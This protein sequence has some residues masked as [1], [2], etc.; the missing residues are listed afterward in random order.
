MAKD[1]ASQ[2]VSRRGL[3]AGGAAAVAGAGL[4]GP[5]RGIADA[6]PG[7][8]HRP[9]ANG[10]APVPPPIVLT[11]GTLL[12]PLTGRVTE[13][14]VIVLANRRV[15]AVA[16]ASKFRAK[17]MNGAQVIDLDD[18]WVVPGLLD[19]HT[20]ATSR[21]S[22][23]RA[24]HAGATTLRIASS[25][26]Y[27]D[28]G[29]QALAEWLPA[30]VPTIQPVGLF[31]RPLLGDDVLSDPRLAP[32]AAS[33]NAP[34]T[35]EELRLLVSVNLSRGAD[36]IKTWATGRAGVCEQDPQQT[37]YD[38]TQLRAIVEAARGRPV[39]CHSHGA[40]GCQNAVQAGVTSLE[41]GTFVTD[42]TLA[43]MRRRGTYFTPTISAVVDL[44]EPGGE[45]DEPCLQERGRTMLPVLEAAVRRAAAL[46]IPIAAGADTSY[47]EASVT[48]VATEVQYLHDAGLPALDALRAATTV[49]ARLMRLQ[50]DA[51]RIARGY[52]AD[53]LVVGASPLDDPATLQ[54][55][56][57]VI[58]GGAV[59]RN[60]L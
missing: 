40:V 2:G 54:S 57:L 29:L 50:G 32:L 42:E 16:D 51:G 48:S 27:A 49:A 8:H 36:H 18:A 14:A 17:G 7:R 30:E 46:G 10:R 52:A 53:V 39:M 33:A 21:A 45:Y 34:Q 12:D 60:Q 43:L 5:G 3:L 55:P 11:G 58:H 35:P 1:G 37:T 41:H 19:A 22:A 59:A 56:K 4:L 6:L 47:S 25:T 24:L 13:D 20:H 15:L 31:V 38:V 44:A 28:V 23:A 26:F 9:Q